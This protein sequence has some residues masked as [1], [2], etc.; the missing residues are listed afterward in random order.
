MQECSS[1]EGFEISGNFDTQIVFMKFFFEKLILKKV[2][3]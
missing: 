1:T 3:R 2:S